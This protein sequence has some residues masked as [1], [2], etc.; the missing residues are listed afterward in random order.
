MPWTKTARRDHARQ[1]RRYSSDLTERERGLA[2]HD[3]GKAAA[4]QAT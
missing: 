2:G 1:G 3:P 4:I